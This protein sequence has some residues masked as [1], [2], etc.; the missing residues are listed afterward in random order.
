MYDLNISNSSS[1]TSSS[2]S[3]NISSSS[4]NN[5][6][7]CRLTW[8][9]AVT[10]LLL[11]LTI[12]LLR[13]WHAWWI[14]ISTQWTSR[15]ALSRLKAVRQSYFPVITLQTKGPAVAEKLHHERDHRLG[16]ETENCGLGLGIGPRTAWSWTWSFTVDWSCQSVA[17]LGIVHPVLVSNLTF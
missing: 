7:I 1:T 9:Y 6:S 11:L 12:G 14:Y 15:T 8:C 13:L 10:S 3:S 17:D 4:S 2:S 16:L 5:K